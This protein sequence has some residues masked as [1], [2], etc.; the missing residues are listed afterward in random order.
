[1][2]TRC[3]TSNRCYQYSL[4]TKEG[5]EGKLWVPR[6]KYGASHA[7]WSTHVSAFSAMGEAKDFFFFLICSK[8]FGCV[9]L[10][11]FL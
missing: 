2:I 5:R 8:S 4:S 1:M 11:L 9:Y 7:C 6:A 10:G 3:F